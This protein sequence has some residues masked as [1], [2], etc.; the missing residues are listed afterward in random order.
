MNE[1]TQTCPIC[2]CA[3][4][5]YPLMVGGWFDYYNHQNWHSAQAPQPIQQFTS[6]TSEKMPEP[7][8]FGAIVEAEWNGSRERFFKNG[9]P[10]VDENW[11]REGQYANKIGWSDLINPTILSEGLK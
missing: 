4:K 7:K 3:I 8:G 11:T 6:T 9:S 10:F 5:I 2:F 1:A